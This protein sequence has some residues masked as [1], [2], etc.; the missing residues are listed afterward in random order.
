MQEASSRPVKSY[1]VGF[2]EEEF[3]EARHA[4]RVAQHLGTDHT[5]ML[6]TGEDAYSLV[7]RIAE[8][9]DEPFANPSQ[10][11]TLLVC[12]LARRQVTVAL[13]GD[14]GDELFGGYNR[15]VYGTRILPRVNRIPRAVRRPVAAAI[16]SVPSAAWDQL[17]PVYG[18]SASWR[19]APAHGGA[20]S[21][22]GRCH[23]RRLRRRHVSVAPLGMAAAGRL[24]A[25]SG[26][27]EDENG[28]ILER[29]RAGTSARPD[30]ARRPDDVSAGRPAGEGR[31]GEHGREPG[32]AAPFS[33]I[34]SWSSRGG[35]RAR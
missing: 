35:C 3:D 18:G 23:G 20:N 33:I 29:S 11:P 17:S 30:D 16:G 8:I 4:A 25:E 10:L 9:F 27:G 15:Y 32:G 19:A 26:A 2:V 14:G 24:L 7:P 28:R 34:E 6:L 12:Q 13:C 22:A 1:T 5:E 21:E 31:P